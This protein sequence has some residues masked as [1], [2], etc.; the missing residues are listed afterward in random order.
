MTKPVRGV[1]VLNTL[2]RI[3]AHEVRATALSFSFVF[4]LMAAYYIMRPV[5]DAMAS[6]W[7][8]AEV[9]F[10]WT[11]NF[12]ICV[13]VV[14]LYGHAVSRLRFRLIVPFVYAFFAATFI[15]FFVAR[16]WGP[17]HQ[18][19]LDKSFFVWVSVFSL[20][21]VSV[22]WSFMS[23]IFT[24]DQANRLFAIIAAGASAGALLGP[25]LPTLFAG[26]LGTNRLLLIA[27][28]MLIAPIPIVLYLGRLR[29]AAIDNSSVSPSHS[30]SDTEKVGGNP[31]AG[32]RLFLANPYLL[33]I[34]VFILLFTMIGSFV[35]FEQKNL[36][37]IYDRETRTRILGAIDWA[38][39]VLTF[40][41]AFFATSRLVKWIGLGLTLALLP[42]LVSSGLLILAFTPSVSVLLGLQVLRRAGNYAITRPARE[43]LFTE[44]TREERFKA[45]PVI[46]TVVYRGGDTL[47]GWLF[48]GLSQGLA[49]SMSAIA[50]VGACIAGVWALAGLFLG[51]LYN[52]KRRGKTASLNES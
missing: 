18:I 21:H 13:V 50:I 51:R 27:A 8:D 15:F 31:L 34:G 41:V 1:G 48:T 30:V 24:R 40:L 6:D 28:L 49:L 4:I 44:V 23:D 39:N 32:F 36:L 42:V 5:R 14:A 25:S 12:F 16:E 2:T 17:Q 46:D 45:K 20:F 33:G 47:S 19:L 10:L 3:E 7:S 26:L 29:N 37:E 35:Y 11:T 22:F 43:M 52:K 38:T 9:S